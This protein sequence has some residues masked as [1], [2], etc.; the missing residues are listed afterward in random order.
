MRRDV[1]WIRKYAPKNSGE[2]INQAQAIQKI[3]TF[4]I[5]YPNVPKRALLLYGPPGVGKTCSVYAIARELGYEV[6]ELNASDVRSARMVHQIL[7]E[8]VKSRPFFFKGRIILID[9]VDGMAGKEDRGGLAALINIANTAR[10]PVIFTANDPWD[11]RFKRLR[12][13]CELVEFKKLTLTDIYKALKRIVLAENLEIDDTVLKTLAERSQGDLRSAIN[14]LQ[15]L[16]NLGRRITMKDL[17]ILGYREREKTIFQALG[18]MFKATTITGA[19]LPFSEVDM[20]PS[21][22]ETWIEE[23]I[24]NEYEDLQEIYEALIW[25]SNANKF[26]SRIYRRQYWGLLKYYTTLMYAGV[27]LSKKQRYKK[28]TRYQMPSRVKKMAQYKSLKEFLA[29]VAKELQ[30]RLHTSLKRIREV[31]LNTLIY[32]L[33]KDSQI[34]RKYAKALGVKPSQVEYLEEAIKR[35]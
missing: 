14:D 19:T 7:D 32:L 3:K 21:E 31:Y 26:Y 13:I 9:E 15:T 8:S 34:G 2:I 11:P 20:D 4:I 28:F 22:I 30:E 10:W 17:S 33:R 24:P 12:E 27:A 5:K 16:A 23:N 18:Q 1:P 6:V 35:L 25:M 29:N